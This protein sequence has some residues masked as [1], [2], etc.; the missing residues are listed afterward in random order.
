MIYFKK[1]PWYKELYM[2]LFCKKQYFISV[3]PAKKDGDYTCIIFG[4]KKKNGEFHLIDIVYRKEIIKMDY[5]GK[6]KHCGANLYWN[7]DNEKLIAKNSA[8]GCLCRVQRKSRALSERVIIP[9]KE[10]SYDK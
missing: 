6:C 3:D 2:K 10:E 7:D 5:I 1:I 9:L 4:Y 8:P